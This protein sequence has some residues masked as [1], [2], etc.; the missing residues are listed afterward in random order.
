MTTHFTHT[1]CNIL[2][3]DKNSEGIITSEQNKAYISTPGE[4]TSGIEQTHLSG[5]HELLTFI[6]NSQ[7]K[8]PDIKIFALF[9]QQKIELHINHMGLIIPKT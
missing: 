5:S 9:N 8:N 2:L 3:Q 4:D 1:D 6:A 7:E